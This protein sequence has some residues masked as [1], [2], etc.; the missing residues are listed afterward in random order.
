MWI[1]K[2][3]IS[4]LD[5]ASCKTKIVLVYKTTLAHCR[6]KPCLSCEAKAKAPCANSEAI[7][8]SLALTILLGNAK[9]AAREANTKAPLRA[10]SIADSASLPLT[11]PSAKISSARLEIKLR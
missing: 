9:P 6:A 5:P 10:N 7:I 4:S 1:A 8:A 11:A 2:S 3:T